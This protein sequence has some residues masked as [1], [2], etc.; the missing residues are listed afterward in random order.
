MNGHLSESEKTETA[1]GKAEK[2]T[3]QARDPPGITSTWG[4]PSASKVKFRLRIV[5]PLAFPF[6]SGLASGGAGRKSECPGP[7]GRFP[8]R[9]SCSWGGPWGY[10][11]KLFMWA[12]G[13]RAWV[14]GVSPGASNN[15]PES[16]RAVLLLLTSHSS[17]TL[18]PRNTLED[19]RKKWVAG[20]PFGCFCGYARGSRTVT[21][22]GTF[23]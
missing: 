23:F 22:F 1:G 17:Q 19:F 5:F 7:A 18:T 10:F 16:G 4:I 6:H 21:Y 13:G 3:V 9:W 8:P 11:V 12:V 20:H 15:T 14:S 2:G